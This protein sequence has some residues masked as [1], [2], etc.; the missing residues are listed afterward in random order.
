MKKLFGII[1]AIVTFVF[2]SIAIVACAPYDPDDD[3]D[4]DDEM[5]SRSECIV[6]NPSVDETDGFIDY[7]APVNAD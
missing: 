6:E 3:D 1:G 7:A 5:M 4:D 2:M